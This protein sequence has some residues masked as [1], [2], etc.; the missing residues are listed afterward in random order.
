[1]GRDG[2]SV[3][4]KV[5]SV[6]EA[7]IRNRTFS[8]GFAELLEECAVSRA[9]LHRTLSDMVESGLLAQD[10]Q[11]E[12]YRL[13]P[14]L[15]SAATLATASVSVPGVARPHMEGLRDE[16]GE[17]VVLAELHGQFVVPVLRADG[18][19]EM[20][21]NQEV[22]RRYQAHAG[23]TGKVLLA[24]LPPEPLAE[25]LADDELERL[26]SNTVTDREG[27][28]ADLRLIR[29]A[30]VGVTLGERVPDAVA[31]S[32]PVFD[33][34]GRA[35]AALTI[36]GIASRYSRERLTADALAVTR[37]AESIS[38][39]AGFRPP[40]TSDLADPHSPERGALETMCDA[41][42]EGARREGV[43]AGS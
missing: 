4:E 22:G 23:A 31:I 19:H 39:E 40:E 24:Q 3:V 27:L 25:L 15:R 7:Y 9:S 10:E 26:T 32:A 21:M 1:V 6:L 5:R 17:T 11:G 18:L 33:A 20:R 34:D 13:G 14:L 29:Q 30:G 43:P 42:W 28:A 41:A 35:V 2:Q 36:S 16:C 12:K 37:V 8:M 38:V